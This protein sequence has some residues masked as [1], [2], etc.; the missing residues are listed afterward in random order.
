METEI[1]ELEEMERISSLYERKTENRSNN[2]TKIDTDV[3]SSSYVT[4]R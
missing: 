4:Y 3:K 2:R 1:Q